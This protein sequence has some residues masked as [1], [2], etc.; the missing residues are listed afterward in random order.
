[1]P[2]LS[3]K[4]QIILVNERTFQKKTVEQKFIICKSITSKSSETIPI[5]VQHIR[6]V[7][8]NT[9]SE[10]TLPI[11]YKNQKYRQKERTI[12]KNQMLIAN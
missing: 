6:S 8:I 12:F 7:S 9:D 3:T 4:N 1:M 11:Y 2:L 10:L 5:F